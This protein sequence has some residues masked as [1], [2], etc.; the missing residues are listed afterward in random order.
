[1]K[2]GEEAVT[3]TDL[4]YKSTTFA[5]NDIVKIVL[6]SRLGLH[7]CIDQS[8]LVR[9]K[10]KRVECVIVEANGDDL[11]YKEEQPE[12]RLQRKASNEWNAEQ[13]LFRGQ[14]PTERPSNHFE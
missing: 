10:L 7:K 9:R 13:L 5:S 11:I 3:T 8:F 12:L 2:E 1:M 14:R 6:G 4:H